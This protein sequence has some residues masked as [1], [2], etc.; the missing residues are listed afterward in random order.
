MDESATR[1]HAASS[2]AIDLVEAPP[3]TAHSIPGTRTES[4]LAG[5]I[6]VGA[7]ALVS[8]AVVLLW[9]P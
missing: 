4:R 2:A 3:V 1:D 5:V 7:G 8:Y 9:V 6:L